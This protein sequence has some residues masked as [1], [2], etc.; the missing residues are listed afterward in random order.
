MWKLEL[1]Q[2]CARQSIRLILLFP[3]KKEL[4]YLKRDTISDKNMWRGAGV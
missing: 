4:R 3:T 2:V 1:A